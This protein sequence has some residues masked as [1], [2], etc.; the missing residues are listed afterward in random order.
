[1][2]LFEILPEKGLHVIAVWN[3]FKLSILIVV[4]VLIYAFNILGRSIWV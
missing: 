2:K 3:L 1:M 4:I